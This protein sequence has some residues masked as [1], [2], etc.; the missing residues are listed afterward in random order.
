M[1]QAAWCFG[2]LQSPPVLAILLQRHLTDLF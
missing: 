2:L 1:E